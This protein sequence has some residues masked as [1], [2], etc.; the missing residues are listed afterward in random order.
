MRRELG[1]TMLMGWISVA[2]IFTGLGV[3]EAAS[4]D[5]DGTYT[6]TITKVELS[7]DGGTTY[8]T[9]FSGSQA[10]NIASANAGAVA[11]GLASG[12]ELDV[13][14]YTVCRVTLDSALVVKGYITV[15]GTTFYTDGT[16][17]TGVAGSNPGAGYATSTF[18]IDPTN[19]TQTYTSLSMVVQPGSSPKVTIKFNTAGVVIADP[20]IG[21]PSVEFS[22]S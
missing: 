9:V 12:V 14:T 10:I 17:F 22:A 2:A 13:G 1:R 5:A 21:P 3:V 8:T 19:R 4:G 7:K 11:A 20:S 15:G 18:T 16:S 6:V